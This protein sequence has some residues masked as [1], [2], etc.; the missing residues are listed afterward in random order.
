MNDPGFERRKSSSWL[1]R[2]ARCVPLSQTRLSCSCGSNPSS[3]PLLVPINGPAPERLPPV[4]DRLPSLRSDSRRESSP[5]S[6]APLPSPR[7]RC[8]RGRP[9]PR[10]P[11]RRSI[12]PT[13]NWSSRHNARTAP[14]MSPA[15]SRRASHRRLRDGRG[16]AALFSYRGTDG[17]E[18]FRFG[19]A[20]QR[21]S[22]GQLVRDHL[23]RRQFPSQ[24]GWRQCHPKS[25]GHKK[26]AAEH[27]RGP[28]DRR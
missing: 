9:P 17:P 5:H 14:R 26:E 12:L 2:T 1:A 19:G 22:A 25:R 7:R 15:D 20:F 3:G 24:H 18:K 16:G 10:S 23:G 11:R 21:Y 4:R 8:S 6:W 28:P 27:E 13:R